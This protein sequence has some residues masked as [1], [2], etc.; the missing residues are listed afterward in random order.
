MVE[1]FQAAYAKAIEENRPVVTFRSTRNL[2]VIIPTQD[3]IEVTIERW[4]E[5][6]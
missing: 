1:D 6:M 3:I 4:Q 2:A 5:R